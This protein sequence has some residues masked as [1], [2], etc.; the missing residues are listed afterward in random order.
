MENAPK[1]ILVF[2]PMKKNSLIF[3]ISVILLIV[4]FIDVSRARIVRVYSAVIEC[5]AAEYQNCNMHQAMGT[6]FL[7]MRCMLCKL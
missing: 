4:Y 5:R 6:V 3:A 1:P 7:F 2:V